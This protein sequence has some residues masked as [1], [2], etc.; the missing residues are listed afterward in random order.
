MWWPAAI[1]LI[2]SCA[3]L[4]I[5]PPMTNAATNFVEKTKQKKATKK[6]Q[7]DASLWVGG[8]LLVTQKI[9]FSEKT[10]LKIKFNA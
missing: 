5:K 1:T 6:R 3:E 2:K 10:S 7:E 9:F 4:G 8:G